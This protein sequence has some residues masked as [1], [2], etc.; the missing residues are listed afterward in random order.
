VATGSDGCF[1]W[2]REPPHTGEVVAYVRKGVLAGRQLVRPGPFGTVLPAIVD[3]HPALSVSGSVRDGDGRPVSGALVRVVW[4]QT[5]A[6][7]PGPDAVAFSDGAGRFRFEG[8]LY[9][10][11]RL[12]FEGPKGG[13][14]TALVTLDEQDIAGV[15]ARLPP[16]WPVTGL[17]RS[18]SGEPVAGARIEESSPLAR[19]P[20]R[21]LRGQHVDWDVSDDGGAFSM[22]YIGRGL[23]AT[24]RDSS[25]HLLS[26][27]FSDA[28]RRPS[29]VSWGAWDPGRPAEPRTIV[30]Q[31]AGVVRGVV[32]FPDGRPTGRVGVQGLV[33]ADGPRGAFMMD[34]SVRAF[35]DEHGHFVLGPLPLGE[36]ALHAYAMAPSLL[37]AR[38]HAARL[39]VQV[40]GEQ[41]PEVEL[42]LEPR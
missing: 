19:E 40:T 39:A 21:R 6:R 33:R 15:D 30:L 8:L 28:E 9:G 25:G 12:Y 31:P 17:L 29:R 5:F 32:R 3:V 4:S 38:A 18:P 20:G 35:S 37:Q 2:F 42:I 27:V 34:R 7:G 36:V 10:N 22:V 23:R 11:Y 16:R 26:A 41:D 1:R 13:V 14:A 24:G